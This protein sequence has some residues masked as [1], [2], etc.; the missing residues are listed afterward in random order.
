VFVQVQDLSLGP[1]PE[2]RPAFVGPDFVFEH[3]YFGERVGF[4]LD[5]L[6]VMF[7]VGEAL[8]EGEQLVLLVIIPCSL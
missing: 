2:G 8:V 6:I 4:F 3:F 1:I 5:E 7:D